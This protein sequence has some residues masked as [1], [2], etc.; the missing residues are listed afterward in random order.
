MSAT[1]YPKPIFM[2]SLSAKNLDETPAI[3]RGRVRHALELLRN[4]ALPRSAWARGLTIFAVLA[5]FAAGFMAGRRSMTHAGLSAPQLVADRATLAHSGPWGQIEYV[6]ISIECPDELL[7]VHTFES[8]VTH[9]ILKGYTPEKWIQL[10]DDLDTSGDL[11][12]E[13]RSPAVLHVMEYGLDVTPTTTIVL[14]LPSKA[15]RELYR[16]LA[17]FPEN[18]SSLTFVLAKSVDERFAGCGVSDATVSLFKKLSCEYGR[19]LVFSD[20][21]AIFTMIP[22][23]EERVR[24]LKALTRQS[25]LLAKLHVTPDSNVEALARYWA[26]ASMTKN[27]RPLLESVARLPGGARISLVNLLPPLAASLIYTFPLPPNPLNGPAVRQDCHW[28]AFNFFREPVDN[29]YSDSEFILQKLKEDHYPVASDPRYGDL[30]LFFT[31][32]GKLI[33]SA[34]YLADNIVFTKNGDTSLHP[35]MFSTVQ[36]LIDQYS[37]M[38]PPDKQLDVQYFRNKYY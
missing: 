6:P 32:E 37:F 10:L 3:A 16:L 9:W 8:K 2:T 1:Q 25:T 20:V 24:F 12:A 7:P 35:W 22:T 15:R 38:V 18:N 14:N 26:K 5:A 34:V 31:P 28:T 13:L 30:V 33:H 29:H 36:D 19:Y 17:S 23:Y 21:A 27:A 11:R 4:K